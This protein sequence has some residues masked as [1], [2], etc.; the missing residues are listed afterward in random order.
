MKQ[1]CLVYIFLLCVPISH[2]QNYSVSSYT[3]INEVSGSFNGVL[4]TEDFFGI[5]IDE[6]GDLDGNGVNDLAV[7][8]NGDDDGGAN[9]GAVWILFL[10]TDDS[11]IASTKISNTS[12]NFNGVLDNNDRF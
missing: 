3:K 2:A 10:D 8:T 4:N 1:L 9:R 5:S 6:I 11:V 7:G 12:G